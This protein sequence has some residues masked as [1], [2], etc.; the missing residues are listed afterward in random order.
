MNS[1][2]QTNEIKNLQPSECK[3][4]GFCGWKKIHK[5]ILFIGIIL[6]VTNL[7]LLF[8]SYN[9]SIENLMKR[10]KN[11]GADSLIGNKGFY[12]SGIANMWP[13]GFTFTMIS[14]MVLA[15][16]MIIY[17]IYH[18]YQKAQ[19][20]FFFGVVNITITF[21]IYW[22]LIFFV[23]IKNGTWSNLRAA[24]PSFVL[25]AINPFI[26]FICLG[27]A[28]KY[29][30]IKKS[31]MWLTNVMVLGYFTWAMIT[32]FI[33]KRL[34]DLKHI[35]NVDNYTRYNIV[36]YQFLNFDQPLF[37][38]GGKLAIVILLDILMFALGALLS[39]TFAWMWKG[40][41]KIKLY[42]PEVDQNIKNSLVSTCQMQTK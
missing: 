26:A 20:F 10:F 8:N 30:S 4:N 5:A 25:H 34:L 2:K 14:N 39:P 3:R 9:T 37:Y 42:T 41:F 16:S 21:V 11:S 1:E 27:F 28:R 6:L 13:V 38:K 19:Y 17:A 23:S 12:P 18:K 22:T 36:V 31:Q 32:F 7:I 15:L 33:G 24:I 40:I 35:P 29:I